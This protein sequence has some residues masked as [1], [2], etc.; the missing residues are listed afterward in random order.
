MEYIPTKP[1]DLFPSILSDN[2]ARP[3]NADGVAIR[4][5]C[6]R[7]RSREE[8]KAI[9]TL[10]DSQLDKDTAEAHD[11]NTLADMFA[12]SNSQR[13]RHDYLGVYASL[14]RHA[15]SQEQEQDAKPTQHRKA[16][17]A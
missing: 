8:R 9:L 15:K 14:Q 1:V 4:A 7:F 12:R 16:S 6:Q 13:E 11:A 10:I 5:F 17:A 2:P 3:L